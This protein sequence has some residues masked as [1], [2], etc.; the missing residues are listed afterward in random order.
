M[1]IEIND[2]PAITDDLVELKCE[3]PSHRHTVSCRIRATSACPTAATA[4]LTNP[5]GRLRFPNPGDTTVTLTVPSDGSWTA[6]QV[7]GENPSLAIGD[8]VIEA[9]CN[10]AT[11]AVKARKGVTVF[12]FDQAE[13][14][15]TPDSD[16]SMVGD[17][18]TAT[19]GVAV[20]YSARARMRPAGVDCTAPQVTNLRISIVQNLVPPYTKTKIWSTPTIV[21]NPGV[22]ARTRADVPSRISFR[23]SVPTATNDVT[24]AA[25]AP[26]YSRDADSLKPPVGCTGGAAATSND[27]PSTPFPATFVF[28]ARTA[29]G[30]EV[31]TVTYGNRVKVIL[32]K[33]FRTWTVVFDTI[34]N[35]ICA[36]RERTWNLHVDSS[37]AA[38][39]RAAAAA[40]DTAPTVDPVTAPPFGNDRTND[41]ANQ[42]TVPEGAATTAFTKT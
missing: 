5:D 17:R 27:T 15:I 9:H 10:T 24:E 6:F 34:T 35:D 40:A 30:V 32:N 1:E 2:T 8:A 11:G 3:H 41:P 13:I 23:I 7:S 38:G 12:S 42:S 37:I 16:Y 31:G 19:A 25:G 20:N 14:T 36:L 29:A 33:N 21:W 39:Q 22:A 26:L 18:Y 28:P 4:V